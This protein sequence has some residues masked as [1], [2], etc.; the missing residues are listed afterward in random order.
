MELL[1]GGVSIHAPL[2]GATEQQAGRHRVAKVSIHAPLKGATQTRFLN[3][4]FELRFNSRTPEG[5]DEQEAEAFKQ[6]QVSIHAPLKGA[7]EKS[8]PPGRR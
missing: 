1:G 7:T 5:C 8:Q 4:T 6:K 3:D 2:K